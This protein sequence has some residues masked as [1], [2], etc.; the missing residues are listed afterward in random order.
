MS[1]SSRFVVALSVV[2]LAAGCGG[3]ASAKVRTSP[4][5][6]ASTVAPSPTPTTLTVHP[7]LVIKK[8]SAEFPNFKVTSGDHC[9]GIDGYDDLR[10]GASVTLYDRTGRAVVGT[11]FV[12]RTA[13]ISNE[14]VLRATVRDLEPAKFYLVQFANRNKIPMSVGDLKSARSVVTIG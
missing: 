2:L 4:R 11:G 12:D 1:G 3:G 7:L 9:R 5:P 14:C 10:K 8:G 13:G 6:S